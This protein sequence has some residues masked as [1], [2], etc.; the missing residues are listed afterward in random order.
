MHRGV[1]QEASTFPCSSRGEKRDDRGKKERKRKKKKEKERK[2][3]IKLQSQS[4]SSTRWMPDRWCDMSGARKES[5]K[6]RTLGI[7]LATTGRGEKEGTSN[8]SRRIC[9]R[10]RPGD[11]ITHRAGRERRELASHHRRN[12]G[13]LRSHS[14][15]RPSPPHWPH[16]VRTV[17]SGSGQRAAGPAVPRP[18]RWWGLSVRAE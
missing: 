14:P 17:G 11:A 3:K 7:P 9:G 13:F 1:V 18:R 2:G 4:A 8:H 16:R 5:R 15:G 12:P 10:V 6:R